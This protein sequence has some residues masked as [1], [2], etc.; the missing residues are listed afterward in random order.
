MDAAALAALELPAIVDRLATFAATDHGAAL[1]RELAPSADLVTV[2]RRHELTSAA[3]DVLSADAA[4]ELT[5]IRDVRPAAERSSR[6]GLL[7]PE[8]LRAIAVSV[9]VA[10][11]A[12]RVLREPVLA[13]LLEPVDPALGG[14]ADEI[15][16]RIEEDGSD[17]R[18]TA[19][20]LLRKLRTEL[21]NGSARVRDELARVARSTDVQD[22]LQESFLAERGG[23]PVLAVRASA[24][25]KVPGVVHDASSTGQTLFVEPFAVV[26]LNNRLAEAAADAR[27]EVERILGELSSA[28][29]TRAD[30]LYALV[31]STGALDLALASGGLS[32]AW[33][34][35][36]VEI[37][38]EVRLIG[39][40]HPLLGAATAVPIDLEL[41]AVR[42]LVI[43]GP[44]TGGKTVALK[45]VGLAALLHQAGLRPPA[46]AASLPV[47]DQVLTDIGDRQSIEMSLSTFSAHLSALVSILESASERSLVLLD[48]VAAGTDPEEGSALAQALL[49]RLVGQARLTVATTHYAELKEWAS[50]CGDAVNGATGF[51][52]ETDEPLYRIALGRPGTSHALRI[53]ERLGLDGA[54]V[55]DARTRVTPER[56]RTAE[57]L[58]DAETAERAAVSLRAELE[59]ALARAQ[60]REDELEREGAKVRAAAGRA[61]QEAVADAERELAAARAEL[62]ALRE[63]LRNARR[64]ERAPD[65]DRLLGSAADRAT[66]AERS[67]HDLSGPLP[68]SAS[69]AEGDPVEAPDV[70]VRGTIASIRGD[71]AEVIGATGQRVRIPLARLRPARERAPEDRAP[72]V[73]VRTSAR[74]DVSD[75]LDVR[76]LAGQEAR[77]QVRRLVDDAALAGLHEI[78]VVHGRGTGA[79][80][81]AVRDELARH[82]LVDDHAADADDGATVATL[83]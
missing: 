9:R 15:D 37:S 69:L 60:T 63:D 14:L 1:A 4:P 80:R 6:G 75:Q 33:G 2:E 72:A 18:D 62:R 21:R 26:E 65:Q 34:G 3:V 55:A 73:Q 79:L 12:R 25:S 83:G 71:D 77:E 61:R 16:R 36:P 29:A 50:V 35:A 49:E 67:L 64:L 41:G 58:A 56:L 20:P 28:V 70:G 81:A 47:F 5:G 7:R 27:E 42:A 46:D 22:A 40:R 53:A 38:A 74:S 11:E 19:S 78:R 45:T 54:V 66:R 57:L 39:A 8:E 10:L 13:A 76:G 32:R 30:A 17:V 23:R 43:S 68:P 31:E 44:N 59:D 24:R 48:E 51:D 52:P 82:P